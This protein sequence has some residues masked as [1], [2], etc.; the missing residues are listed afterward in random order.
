MDNNYIKD[1]EKYLEEANKHQEAMHQ[2][3]RNNQKDLID[4]YDKR[5]G[6]CTTIAALY[7]ELNKQCK[8]T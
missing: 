8:D 7:I 2:A 5:V 4:V 3:W 1:I 6:H